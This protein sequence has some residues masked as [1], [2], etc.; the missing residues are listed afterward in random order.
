MIESFGGTVTTGISGK[1]DYLLVGD[2]AG[3]KRQ[4]EATKKKV[5]ILDKMTFA[6]ILIGKEELPQPKCKK[7]QKTM[8]QFVKCVHDGLYDV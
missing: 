4:E 8:K 2:E 5:P 1:T 6:R 3:V 7:S